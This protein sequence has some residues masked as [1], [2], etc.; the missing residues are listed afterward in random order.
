[1]D[2]YDWGV[3]GSPFF[4]HIWCTHLMNKEKSHTLFL[5]HNGCVD[6]NYYYYPYCP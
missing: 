1:M 6:Y 4:K 5:T 2:W 3:F